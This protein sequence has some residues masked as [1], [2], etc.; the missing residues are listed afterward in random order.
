VSVFGS[1]RGGRQEGSAVSGRDWGRSVRPGLVERDPVCVSS[2]SP[3]RIVLD[4]DERMFRSG[5][6][7]ALRADAGLDVVGESTSGTDVFS[8]IRSVEPD[9]VLLATRAPEHHGLG[10]LSRLRECFPDVKVIVCPSSA[11]VEQIEAAFRLGAAGCV[12]T[13][14][15]PF[16]IAASVRRVLEATEYRSHDVST[17]GED[18]VAHLRELR[19][20]EPN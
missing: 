4:D 18:L 13:T 1:R 14:I 8:I 9:A 17:I 7:S 15:D 20:R 12:L 6:A 10:R 5:I 2:E 16:A 3:L 19:I 11:D